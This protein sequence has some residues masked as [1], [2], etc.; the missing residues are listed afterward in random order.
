MQT[1]EY[2]YHMCDVSRALKIVLI[3][4]QLDQLGAIGDSIKSIQET[5]NRT[6]LGHRINHILGR[7]RRSIRSKLKDC[8]IQSKEHL[9]S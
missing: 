9:L 1:A 8:S 7:S 3:K 2:T 6:I 5:L 4:G